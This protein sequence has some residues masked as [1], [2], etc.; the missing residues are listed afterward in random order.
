MAEAVFRSITTANPRVSLVDSAGT[1]AYHT[2]DAP[3]PRTM[4]TLEDH[5]IVDYSHGARKVESVDLADF[6]YVLAMDRDNLRNLQWL[7]QRLVKSGKN[8][9]KGNI[10]LFGDFGGARGEEVVDPYYGAR[11]GF[12]IAHEQ[13]V[14]FSTG[15]VEQVLGEKN[16]AFS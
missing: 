15:F 8:A 3:D 14:R 5:G 10:M 16:I 4:R 1:G 2:G 11:N 7:R 9:G 6:D 13:M 12:D